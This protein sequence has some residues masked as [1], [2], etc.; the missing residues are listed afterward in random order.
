MLWPPPTPSQVTWTPS[1]MR[2]ARG[3]RRAGRGSVLL[4]HIASSWLS[5]FIFSKAGSTTVHLPGS[6]SPH[7]ALVGS[8]VSER[9]DRGQRL[10]PEEPA[11]SVRPAVHRWEEAQPRKHLPA[12]LLG[13]FCALMQA[14]PCNHRNKDASSRWGLEFCVPVKLPVSGLFSAPLRDHYFW[15][16]GPFGWALGCLS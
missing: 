7:G 8:G 12:V 5:R 11:P 10:S 9:S 2:G 3:V 1:Q 15:R 6:D 4:G 14:E 16:P 13:R